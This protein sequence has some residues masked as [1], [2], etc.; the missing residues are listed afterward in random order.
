MS[1]KQEILETLRKASFSFPERDLFSEYQPVTFVPDVSRETITARFIQEVTE[2]GA[3]V[4]QP[5]SPSNAVSVVLEIIGSEEKVMAW[6]FSQIPLPGLSEELTKKHITTTV[7]LD[8]SINIGITGADAALASTGTIIL[9][10]GDEKPSRVSLL[11]K[12]HVAILCKDQILPNFEAWAQ[13]LAANQ[14]DVFRKTSSVIAI[15]GPSR[16]A[17]IAMELIIGMHGPAELH[18]VLIQ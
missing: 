17:D 2:L 10:N 8:P 15:S 13:S 11:P 9:F 3:Y 4:Y 7:A 12:K 18:I 14:F 16:T 6:D 1:S 5:D